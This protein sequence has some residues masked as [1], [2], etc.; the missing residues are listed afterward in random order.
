MLIFHL[1]MQIVME[2]NGGFHA[3]TISRQHFSPSYLFL[4]SSLC[5][6]FYYFFTHEQVRSLYY[7]KKAAVNRAIWM[8]KLA[9]LFPLI[10]VQ[11]LTHADTYTYIHK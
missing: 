5:F 9:D 7:L 1:S 8:V 2:L 4:Y 6:S 10:I 11:L 3:I